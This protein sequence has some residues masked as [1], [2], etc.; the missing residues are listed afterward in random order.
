MQKNDLLKKL[1]AMP[2]RSAW[3]RGVRNYAIDLVDGLQGE[4]I[5]ENVEQLKTALLNGAQ[6]WQQYSEGGC[7]LV[8]NS[9][10]AEALCSPSELKRV[11]GGDRNPNARED[12]IACQARALCQA[13]GLIKKAVKA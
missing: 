9:D 11:K 1:E 12:W 13:W 7:A 5:P 10:I 8:Y 4:D 3:A 2:A 6:S